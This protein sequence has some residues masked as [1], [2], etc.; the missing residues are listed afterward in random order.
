MNIYHGW[1]DLK[2]GVGDLEFAEKTAAYFEHL[3]AQGLLV[4]YLSLIHI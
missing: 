3:K 1:C 2:P 4:S